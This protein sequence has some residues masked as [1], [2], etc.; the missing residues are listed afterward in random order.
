MR[1]DSIER[2]YRTQLIADVVTGKLDVREAAWGLPEEGG[3][4]DDAEPVTEAEE[5]LEET[6]NAMMEPEE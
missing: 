6:D 3:E 1:K 2:E 4:A 5:M